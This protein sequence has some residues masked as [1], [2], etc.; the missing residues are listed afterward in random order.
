MLTLTNSRFSTCIFF[1]NG[2]LDPRLLGEVG[3]LSP[4][5]CPNQSNEPLQIINFHERGYER[6]VRFNHKNY[7]LANHLRVDNLSID[8]YDWQL[9]LLNR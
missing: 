1:H 3:D 2:L 6:Y 8:K 7:T 9:D 4:T 5:T